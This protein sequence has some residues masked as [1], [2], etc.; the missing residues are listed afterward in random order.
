M[1][2]ERS[3]W[4]DRTIKQGS[5]KRTI[6]SPPRTTETHRKETIVCDKGM[7]GLIKPVHTKFKS[8][9]ELRIMH[10]FVCIRVH[11]KDQCI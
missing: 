2:E 1:V 3:R 8:S 11:V 7:G 9:Q 4:S 10:S 6:E 5:D